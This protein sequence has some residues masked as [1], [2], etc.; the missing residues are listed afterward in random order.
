MVATRTERGFSLLELV[1]V[2]SLLALLAGLV[3]STHKNTSRKAREA[4]L[5]NNLQQIRM[6]LDQY[7]N[8]K[9]R[10]PPS[11][12]TLRD[13]GYLREIPLDPITN[14]R[15]SWIIIFEELTGDED[16]NYE[17]GVY[18]VKSGSEAEAID[19]TFYYEW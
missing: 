15:E 3:T 18:D 13:E 4:V 5:R 7:N 12:E 1:L 6:A 10:Y 16:S 9:R 11:L 14:S 19:G 2:L 8:D 17:A